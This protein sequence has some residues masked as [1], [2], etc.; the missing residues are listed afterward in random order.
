MC[1]M[2]WM[3]LFFASLPAS[4]S[5]MKWFECRNSTDQI[6]FDCMGSGSSRVCLRAFV[7]NY[8][9]Q[10]AKTNI[11]GIDPLMPP[12]NSNEKTYSLHV[13]QCHP[14]IFGV[15]HSSL[16][17]RL[18]IWLFL[19]RT[20][21]KNPFIPHTHTHTPFGIYFSSA[22]IHWYNFY[23]S[24]FFSLL[25]F[26][27][28]CVLFQIVLSSRYEICRIKTCILP[29]QNAKKRSERERIGRNYGTITANKINMPLRFC[30]FRLQFPYKQ[31]ITSAN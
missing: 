14:S 10:L 16:I 22:F 5:W 28:F 4:F 25:L 26:S 31:W 18:T 2:D 15:L 20:A 7:R 1:I 12:H 19:I 23:S 9:L 24:R 13:F 8:L 30:W 17:H 27:L 3:H 11:N 21:F 6:D 29:F